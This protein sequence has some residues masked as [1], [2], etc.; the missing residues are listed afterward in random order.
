MKYYNNQGLTMN[1]IIGPIITIF[2]LA[3]CSSTSETTE[4]GNNQLAQKQKKASMVC[5]HRATTGSHRRK[6]TCMSKK[7][8]KELEAE[9]REAM[10]EI[11]KRGNYKVKDGL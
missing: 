7:L 1:K 2:F 10:R 6:K 11:Q 9:N 5:E 3:G 4:G 8:A